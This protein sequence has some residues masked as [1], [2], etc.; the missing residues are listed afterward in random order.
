[1]AVAE[2][3]FIVFKQRKEDHKEHKSEE[4]KNTILYISIWGSECKKKECKTAKRIV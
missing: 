4:A 3:C 1:M 2:L